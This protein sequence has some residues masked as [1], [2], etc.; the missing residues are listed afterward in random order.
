MTFFVTLL[1]T[2]VYVLYFCKTPLLVKWSKQGQ[3]TCTFE[4]EITTKKAFCKRGHQFDSY[5][6]EYHVMF[7]TKLGR[8]GFHIGF[9]PGYAWD[10]TL[11]CWFYFLFLKLSK[12]SNARQLIPNYQSKLKRFNNFRKHLKVF[13]PVCRL[14]II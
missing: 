11:T 5:L 12:V 7:S 8:P 1:C 13:H 2:W 14:N 3:N 10:K 4:K 9:P 6:K